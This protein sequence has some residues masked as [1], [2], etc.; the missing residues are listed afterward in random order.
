[1]S[2]YYYS[3]S[4]RVHT[5]PNSFATCMQMLESA[6]SAEGGDR[7]LPLALKAPSTE[8]DPLTLV[9]SRPA[10]SRDLGRV[11]VSCQ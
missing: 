5:F 7:T 3:S 10:H 9:R 2:G 6:A 1:M 11:E 4:I 8:I